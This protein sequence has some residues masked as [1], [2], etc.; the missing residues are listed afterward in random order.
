MR[1]PGVLRPVRDS[2]IPV[3]CFRP[4]RG[5]G[6]FT[7][8]PVCHSPSVTFF[9][10]SENWQERCSAIARL[11]GVPSIAEGLYSALGARSDELEVLLLL[12][13]QV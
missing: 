7:G 9:V 1:P 12:A 10:C 8:P 4:G 6:E 3:L 13:D 5:D 2:R 11:L